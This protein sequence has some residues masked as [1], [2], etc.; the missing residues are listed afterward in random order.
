MDIS[1]QLFNILNDPQQKEP[2]NNPEVVNYLLKEMYH[3]LKVTDAPSEIFERF[4]INP[5]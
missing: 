2:L 4:K 1:S 5:I 3:H